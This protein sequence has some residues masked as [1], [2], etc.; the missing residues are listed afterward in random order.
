M[1]INKNVPPINPPLAELNSLTRSVDQLRQGVESLGG[2]RG[3]PMDRAVTF[4]DLIQ[5]GLIS[6]ATLRQVLK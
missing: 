3:G 1:A 6:E 2:L 4:S 5:L